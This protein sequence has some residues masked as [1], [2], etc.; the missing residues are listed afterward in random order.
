M[1]STALPRR[2]NEEV[3]GDLMFYKQEHNIFHI[4]DRCMR[5]ATGVEI[6][7]KTMTSILDGYHQCWVQFGPAK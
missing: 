2:F 7:G 5:Y 1:S 3:E 6:P 4:T